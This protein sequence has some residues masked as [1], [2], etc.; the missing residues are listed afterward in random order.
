MTVKRK[1]LDVDLPGGCIQLPSATS[2]SISGRPTPHVF[3]TILGYINCD[4]PRHSFVLQRP[5][6]TMS[7]AH[8]A[9]AD[10]CGVLFEGGDRAVSHVPLRK[11]IINAVV[12]DGTYQLR[13]PFT[14]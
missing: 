7:L 3:C 9:G 6:S 10:F 14:S 12:I 4:R 8:P 2:V 5:T 11:S 13:A 1:N